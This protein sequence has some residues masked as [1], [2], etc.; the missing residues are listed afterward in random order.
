MSRYSFTG[1][2]SQN[3]PESFHKLDDEPRLFTKT[4]RDS[5]ALKKIYSKQPSVERTLKHIPV[6]YDIENLRLRAE[7]RWFWFTT[8][9]GINQ[10]LVKT[11]CA[12]THLLTHRLMF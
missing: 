7:K 9:V 1:R 11:L 10:H 2:T 12:F 3:Q 5:K 8:L 4:P 6:D